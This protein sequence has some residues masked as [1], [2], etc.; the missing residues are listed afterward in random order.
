MKIA[1]GMHCVNPPSF[2]SLPPPPP[3][4]ALD[5]ILDATPFPF[6]LELAAA[7]ASR[8]D[9]LSLDKWLMDHLARDDG[10][11]FLLALLRFLDAK[12][13]VRTGQG[14]ER[15]GRR[16]RT[17]Q[18]VSRSCI[19]CPLHPATPALILHAAQS[20]PVPSASLPCPHPYILHAAHS[21]P[22]PLHR[23]PSQVHLDGTTAVAVLPL[24]P[25]TRFLCFFRS[26]LLPCPPC[27][28]PP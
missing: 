11:A 5:L 1:N 23:S 22:A 28:G 15:G 7:A 25:P 16:R 10:P 3:P 4:Q 27:S 6:S 2:F 9:L 8:S 18:H 17:A 20:P 14:L 19:L 13:Q 12:T 21:S 26:F 24:P